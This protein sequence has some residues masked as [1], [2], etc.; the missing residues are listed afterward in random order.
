MEG[1]EEQEEQEEQEEM[2]GEAKSQFGADAA[3][4]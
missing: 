1:E 2:E 4:R 3:Q